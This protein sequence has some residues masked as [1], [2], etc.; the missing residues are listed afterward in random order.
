MLRPA[1]VPYAE[2]A[3]MDLRRHRRK[4]GTRACRSCQDPWPCARHLEVAAALG[5]Q[6]GMRGWWLA[7]PAL[8]GMLLL[9]AV[10]A[11]VIP[12]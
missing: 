2:V 11:G 1:A 10:T 4:L 7:G 3:R 12:W 8:V 6:P 5:R 9:A